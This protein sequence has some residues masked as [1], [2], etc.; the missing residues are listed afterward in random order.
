MQASHGSPFS[1]EACQ[2]GQTS[3][4]VWPH[5]RAGKAVSR[6]LFGK[7]AE[8]LGQNVYN[9]MWAQVLR[10][11]GF[12]PLESFNMGRHAAN[13][14]VFLERL[15]KFWDMP[16]LAEA[17]ALGVA[18][19]W[20][21]YGEGEVSY[22]LDGSAFGSGHCQQIA[23]RSAAGAAGI[24]Q[25][26]FLP[27]HRQDTFD[28]CFYAR[29][30]NGLR[31][32]V[33]TQERE[34]ARADVEVAG[35]EWASH[36]LTLKVDRTALA[37]GTP[38][39]FRIKAVRA[40]TV[41]L[42]QAFLFPVDHMTGFDPD[43]VRMLRESKLPL[44]RYPGGNFVSGYH[45]KD[46][47]GP[48]HERPALPNP[49]WR[50]IEPNHVGTDEF[51]AF[52]QMVGCEAL[53]CVN[54]GDG[55]AEEA[56]QWVQYCNGSPDTEYGALRVRNGHAEP[57][58]VKWWEIGN[59]LWGDWQIGHCT[60]EEYADRYAAFSQAMLG[61][62]PD[63]KLIACGN[64]E[65]WH[66]PLIEKR[67]SMLRCCSIHRLIGWNIPKDAPADQVYRELV[68][69]PVALKRDLARLATQMRDGGVEPKIAIT[70][71]MEVRGTDAL[72]E[73]LFL[74][75]VIHTCIREGQL[76]ELITH[77]ALVNHGG[78]LRKEREIVYANPVHYASVLY[79]TQ[80]GIWP[81]R[82]GVRSPVYDTAGRFLPR[83]EETPLLDAVALLDESGNEVTLL[84]VNRGLQTLTASVS[85]HGFPVLDQIVTRT[86]GADSYRSRN[87]WEEP[88]T[89]HLRE[90]RLQISGASLRY[91]FSPH[92]LVALVFRRAET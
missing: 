75:G 59:E 58:N 79:G 56:A 62:D 84:V 26:V 77:T 17:P 28:F 2:A 25:P 8:H 73:A 85:L 18:P 55:T 39:R 89:V 54:A 49:A 31:I 14:E 91:T 35:D 63:I 37:R 45:W 92:S 11:T 76:V 22:A 83:V 46:G 13:P 65:A 16:G 34:I 21:P 15:A 33:W 66:A 72:G 7:F 20:S 90:G 70:E 82:I 52:C 87:T 10:N 38:L 71:L 19:L 88:D 47:I 64:N 5:D 68:A 40:G 41:W 30:A 12:E 51:M 78:G 43:V 3:I 44:L 53:I 60:A 57:Y 86:L 67:S 29:G 9:G 36:A 23:V 69:Y 4:D 1:F 48:V 81:V 42:D 32:S 24:E 61:A 50:G 6:R 74:A 27:L 80:S